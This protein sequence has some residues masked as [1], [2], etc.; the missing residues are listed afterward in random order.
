M[1]IQGV[2]LNGVTV[3]DAQVVTDGLRYYIDAGVASSYPGSGTNIN[4]L[5]GTAPGASSLVNAPVFSSA[6]AA[7]YFSFNG[8]NQYVYT[9]DLISQS[10][11]NAVTIE[12]WINTASDNG[13]VV[14]EQ[15]SASPNT[16]WYDSNIEIVSGNLKVAIWPFSIG[17]GIVVGAVSRNTWQ[18]YVMTYAAGTC[19]GYINGSITNSFS[20]TRNYGSAAL[21]YGVML[22]TP[23]NLGDGSY[24]A[25][26]WS[27]LR[28]YNRAL[29]QAEIQQNFNAT[30]SRYS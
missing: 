4:N 3:V 30:N 23:T 18:Q 9:P 14:V 25:G 16:F 27:L 8:T 19:R 5:A 29:N 7:S 26:D 21:Y 17:G 20:N 11:T 13:V 6:G 28:I 12:C 15:G 2:T 1:I 10:L 24:L 22:G